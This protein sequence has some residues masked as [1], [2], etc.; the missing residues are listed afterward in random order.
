M[1]KLYQYLWKHRMLGRDLILD[2]GEKLEIL[3]PG[4]LNTDAG[5]DFSGARIRIDGTEWIGN[6]EIHVKA[7]DWYRHGHHTDAS[8]DSVVLHVVAV[9]D[10][11]ICRPDGLPVP[12]LTALFPESFFRMYAMLSDGL[13]DVRCVSCIGEVPRIEKEGW[14]EALAVERMQRKS[15]RILSLASSFG[16]DWEKTCFVTLARALGFGLNGEPFEIMAS[17]IP[18][19]Y[20]SRH[21]DNPMQIEAMLF[22]QAGMLDGSMHIFDEY[23]QRLCREYGFLAR[24]YGLRPMNVSIWKYARTRP[25]NFPHRRIAYLAAMADGGFSLMSRLLGAGGDADLSRSLLDIRL[26]GYWQ[27]H[28]AFGNDTHPGSVALGK[29]SLDL[30][31]INFVAP[32]LYAHGA[33]LGDA[34]KAE[35]GL[36]LWL[37]L[38]AEKN[39]VVRYWNALGLGCDSAMRSQALLQLRKEYCDAGKCLECRIGHWLLRERTSRG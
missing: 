5:P 24:K 15:A 33:S 30:L 16:G 28:S 12:Q 20:L 8:Y 38:D 26:G 32:L 37:S 7:S 18:L 6:V 1:E 39:S 4:K 2:G 31:L 36:G 27:T 23:Y 11:R 17:G 14:L 9:A 34:V 10:T 19:G 13:E 29:A 22:G 25:S 21:A 3:F 35:R